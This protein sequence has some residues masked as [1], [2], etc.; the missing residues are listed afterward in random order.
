MMPVKKNSN[1]VIHISVP[2]SVGS[3]SLGRKSFCYLISET[4]LRKILLHCI[5]LVKNY[6][7]RGGRKKPLVSHA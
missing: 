2:R 5:G 1:G 4:F 3:Y 7:D 6:L